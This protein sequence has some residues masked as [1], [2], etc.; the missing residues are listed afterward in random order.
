MRGPRDHHGVAAP[1]RSSNGGASSGGR[2][3]ARVMP[4]AWQTRPGPEHSSRGSS[5]PRR[6]AHRVEALRSARSRGSARRRRGPPRGRRSSGTSG[7]RRSGRRRRGPAGRTSTRVAR[8][9]TGE[10]VRGRVFAVVG[11]GL[12]DAPADAV[13]QQHDADQLARHDRR[14]AEANCLRLRAHHRRRGSP[15]APRQTGSRPHAACAA[16]PVPHF[17]Q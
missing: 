7:C 16:A 6:C 2:C 14:C 1:A 9:R 4:S 10:A 5:R 8:R 15:H 11:L 3:S 12:D 17:G 13:D